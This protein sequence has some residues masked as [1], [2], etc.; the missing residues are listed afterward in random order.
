MLARAVVPDYLN[1]DDSLGRY[2]P[3]LAVVD[4]GIDE[5][6]GFHGGLATRI[7]SSFLQKYFL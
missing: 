7:F 2:S 3:R 1:S 4:S 5:L 6:T